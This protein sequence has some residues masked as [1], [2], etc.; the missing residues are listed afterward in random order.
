MVFSC[1]LY[2]QSINWARLIIFGKGGNYGKV[3]I[4]LVLLAACLILTATPAGSIMTEETDVM[5]ETYKG[6]TF[7][8]YEFQ[9][10]NQFCITV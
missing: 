10:G 9:L 7:Y 4:A 8:S 3:C 5:K 6:V 2:Q 1:I